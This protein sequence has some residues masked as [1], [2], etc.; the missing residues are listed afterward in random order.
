MTVA[1]ERVLVTKKAPAAS[2]SR[3]GASSEPVSDPELIPELIKDA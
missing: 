2:N 3:N 1:T